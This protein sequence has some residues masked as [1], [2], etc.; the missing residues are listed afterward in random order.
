ME[1]VRAFDLRAIPL[2]DVNSALHA[3][4]L[5]GEFVISHPDGAHSV[6]VG[7]DAA[8][9]SPWTVTSATTPPG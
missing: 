5:S 2:R 8:V 7:M 6:A 1:Q 4:D 9:R 3:P